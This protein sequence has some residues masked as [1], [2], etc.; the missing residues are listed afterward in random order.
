MQSSE[1]KENKW[2]K[3]L[4]RLVYIAVFFIALRYVVAN[5]SYPEPME[6][7]TADDFTVSAA[8][9]T[10]TS[11]DELCVF[12]KAEMTDKEMFS[13]IESQFKVVFPPEQ[14]PVITRP[15]NEDVSYPATM[16][17]R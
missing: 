6:A 10:D 17:I 12:S 7:D 5:M 1:T 3:L 16:I 13:E 14:N 9:N 8:I 11:K 2:I 15:C 4:V